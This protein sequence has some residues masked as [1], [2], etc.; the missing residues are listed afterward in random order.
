[1]GEF[2]GELC[3]QVLLPEW[4]PPG[5][6]WREFIGELEQNNLFVMSVGDEGVALRYHHLFQEFLRD[7]LGRELPEDEHEILLRLTEA[8]AA[9]NDWEMAHATAQQLDD[10]GVVVGVIEQGGLQMVRGGRFLLVEQWFEGLPPAIVH[11]RPLL[12]LIRGYSRVHDGHVAEGLALLSEAVDR[13]EQSDGLQTSIAQALAYRSIAHRV[14]GNYEEALQ[15]AE[16]A[17]ALLPQH[18][19]ATPYLDASA[20]GNKLQYPDSEPVEAVVEIR[21]LA[22]HNQGVSLQR[23]GQPLQGVELLHA[24]LADY[25]RLGDVQNIAMTQYEIAISYSDAGRHSDALTLFERALTIWQQ[26]RNVMGQALAQNSIGVHYHDRGEYQRA[27][28]ALAEALSCARRSGYTRLEAFSLTSLGDIYC[29]LEM[30]QAAQDVYQQAYIIARRTDERFLILYL[31]LARA[32]VAWSVEDWGEAYEC[33]DAAGQ[34]VLDRNSS[35]EWGL[36]RLAIGRYYLAQ[37][38]A[39]AALEPLDD[40]GRCFQEGGQEV[41]AAKSFLYLANATYLS[42]DTRLATERLEYAVR[43]IYNLEL[44]HP[45]VVAARRKRAVLAAVEVDDNSAGNLGRLLDE[46]QAFETQMPELVRALRRKTAEALPAAEVGS[47]NIAVRTLGRTEVLV[48][49][50]PI[51]LSQWQT[52]IS[53]D[54]FFCF[55]A[56]PNG[57]TKEQIGTMFWPDCSA[58]QLKTRFKNAIYRLRNALGQDVVLF[59]DTNYFFDTSLD[60]EYDVEL[61]LGLIAEA[62]EAGDAAVRLKRLEA[63]VNLYGGDYLPDVDED[64]PRA[65]RERLRT[66]YL[67]SALD[68]AQ[69]HFEHGA[70]DET[71]QVCQRLLADDPCLEEVHRLAMRVHASSGNRSGSRAAIRT[72]PTGSARRDRCSAFT[73]D[74]TTL[75]SADGLICLEQSCAG[76]ESRSQRSP[77]RNGCALGSAASTQSIAESLCKNAVPVRTEPGL[78]AYCLQ[79]SRN[80]GNVRYYGHP[81][82]SA[83]GGGFASST[84]FDSPKGLP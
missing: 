47:P 31:E 75:C 22:L 2:D 38:N 45:L 33:L 26:A 78:V 44:R 74:G 5:R 50:N 72:M 4:L 67:E 82:R 42:G 28:E 76:H 48:D 56:F 79:S 53:R 51:P 65:E 10:F 35:Y 40:A 70:L 21:A 12:A 46:I 52:R 15:D 32:V 80:Y 19:S 41:D 23:M 3:E 43:L 62:R 68:L 64:W 57:L 6:T 49:G 8:Y 63:A 60:Y 59:E 1:M 84:N 27:F 24:A 58:Q 39:A 69:L 61:F 66:I 55:L 25:E 37:Q 11:S 73:A 54:L 34:L 83:M 30:W 20:S 17:L 16:G 7:R 14:L 81:W 18:D 9:R 77:S 13:F 29:D 71:L 36:Y